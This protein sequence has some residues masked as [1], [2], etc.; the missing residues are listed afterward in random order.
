MFNFTCR[1]YK[2]TKKIYRILA[3]G[4]LCTSLLSSSRNRVVDNIQDSISM[5]KT[6]THQDIL[7]KM[8]AQF[9]SPAAKL[10]LHLRYFDVF[11]TKYLVQLQVIVFIYIDHIIIFTNKTN[12]TNRYTYHSSKCN[13]RNKF[14]L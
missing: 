12:S 4:H 13:S 3:M 7:K 8:M 9:A 6:L 14:Q 1:F 5:E 11:I 10:F 2:Y